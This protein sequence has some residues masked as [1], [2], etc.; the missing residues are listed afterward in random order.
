MS[1]RLIPVRLFC[2]PDKVSP[3]LTLKWPE[4]KPGQKE[5]PGPGGVNLQRNGEVSEGARGGMKAS[6]A[7]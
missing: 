2:L 5:T 1:P 6:P 7:E 4:Q 3:T